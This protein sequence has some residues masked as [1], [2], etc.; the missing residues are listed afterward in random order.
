[1]KHMVQV[2]A[3]KIGETKLSS[4]QIKQDDTHTKSL[5]IYDATTIKTAKKNCTYH[6]GDLVK[7][8]ENAKSMIENLY[9]FCHKDNKANIIIHDFILDQRFF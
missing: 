6:L 1:M 3:Q 5:K 9:H 4:K 2:F 8:N 7:N